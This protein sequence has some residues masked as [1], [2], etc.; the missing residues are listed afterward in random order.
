MNSSMTCIAIPTQNPPFRPAKDG[1]PPFSPPVGAF[2]TG[3]YGPVFCHLNGMRRRSVP[4]RAGECDAAGVREFLLPP[5][6]YDAALCN[7]SPT[8]LHGNPTDRPAQRAR[9]P[10]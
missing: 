9:P 7:P 6:R 8:E 1:R 3:I 4:R 5:T 10:L 2:A